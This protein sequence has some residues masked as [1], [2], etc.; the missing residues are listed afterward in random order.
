VKWLGKPK[1]P[2]EL[3]LID[4]RAEGDYKLGHLPGAVWMPVEKL[5]DALEAEVARRFPNANRRKL[6]LIFYCYGPGCIRSRNGS[7]IAAQH[8]YLNLLWFRDGTLGW[9]QT[10]EKLV[11][12]S[13]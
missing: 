1:P 10:G 7:T 3:L 5:G 11:S 8:G 9:R 2:E 13:P 12:S 4:L 6:P